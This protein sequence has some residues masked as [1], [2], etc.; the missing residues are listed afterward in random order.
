MH[1]AKYDGADGKRIYPRRTS[2]TRRWSWPASGAVA[3]TRSAATTRRRHESWN[4][5]YAARF[6]KRGWM[7][8]AP[9]VQRLSRA[10]QR[11][12]RRL[13]ISGWAARLAAS[14]QLHRAV[15]D[16]ARLAPRS[17]RR[18]RIHTACGARGARLRL[19]RR[20]ARPGAADRRSVL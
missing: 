13:S 12:E 10:L 14:D 1:S 6:A 16:L 8:G 17:A 3:A 11:S 18:R 9:G 15:R 7:V 2:P 4:A 20:R 5:K 19:D